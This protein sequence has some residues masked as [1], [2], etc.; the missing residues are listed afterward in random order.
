MSSMPVRIGILGCGRY[1]STAV[2]YLK[3]NGRYDIVA[4]MDV[5]SEA[6]KR[7]A[8]R[9]SVKTYTDMDAFLTHDG[10]E[11]VSINTP[12]LVHAE[13]SRSCL[14]AGKHVF[15]TKPISAFVDEAEKVVALARQRGLVYIVGHHGR[16]TPSMRFVSSLLNEKKIGRLCNVLITC[17]SS[18][19]LEQKQDDW[20]TI[21]EQN[22]GGPLLQCG[23]HTIDFLLGCFGRVKRLF[24]MTQ[25]DITSFGVI[26]NSA[27]LMEFDNGVQVSFVCNYTTAYMHTMNFFG[28]EGNLHIHKHIS[29]LN[30]EQIYYQPRRRGE[31]EPWQQLSIPEDIRSSE[32]NGI[33]ERIFAEQIRSARP[34]YDN[35]HDA[36]EA[37][38]VVHAAV[39]SSETGRVVCLS[40]PFSAEEKS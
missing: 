11:A 24:A 21:P 38:R 7:F 22:P 16:H 25:N 13:N 35:A 28:T 3:D 33:L 26:D 4:C 8:A 32:G 19:G 30:E 31:H 36:I 23:I 40:K 34:C 2:A 18:S 39:E 10:M 14:R 9:E 1:S 12:V 17:C 20:R 29:D 15:V 37:L 27:N 5:S 6:A